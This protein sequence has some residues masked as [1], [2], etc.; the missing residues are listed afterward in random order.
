MQF[1]IDY[2]HLL[3]FGFGQ[4]LSS[5]PVLPQQ[6]LHPPLH[7]HEDESFVQPHPE[8]IENKTSD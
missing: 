1:I 3:S 6:H 4:H 7:L 8:K 2:I 5:L